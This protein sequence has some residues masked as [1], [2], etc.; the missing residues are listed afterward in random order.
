MCLSPWRDPMHINVV[1][2]E[3]YLFCIWHELYLNVHHS[4]VS[5]WHFFICAT[6]GATVPEVFLA[7]A[8]Q[9]GSSLFYLLASSRAPV[10]PMSAE[11]PL[12]S[13]VTYR[14]FDI[15]SGKKLTLRNFDE[16]FSVVL[17]LWYTASFFIAFNFII[18]LSSQPAL[19]E[20][21][22]GPLWRRVSGTMILQLCDNYL[23]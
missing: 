10:I 13:M 17:C 1:D 14:R 12:A 9:V 23:R 3:W 21:A 7:L 5:L 11:E 8:C 16:V 22:R 4:N 6:V 2:C 20:L 18:S 15:K 19:P